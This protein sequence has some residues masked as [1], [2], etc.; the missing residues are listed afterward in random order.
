VIRIHFKM[1]DCALRA[2]WQPR[3][4]AGWPRTRPVLPPARFHDFGDAAAVAHHDI[5]S[6]PPTGLLV[7][8]SGSDPHTVGPARLPCRLRRFAP[9]RPLSAQAVARGVLLQQRPRLRRRFT[10]RWPV[11]WAAGVPA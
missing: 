9:L 8:I 10:R 6:L 5:S 11:D 3:P 4:R 7:Q 2:R 1:V